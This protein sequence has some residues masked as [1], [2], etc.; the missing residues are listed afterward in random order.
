LAY[1]I[2]ARALLFYEVPPCKLFRTGEGMR[3]LGFAQQR[4]S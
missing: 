3:K 4:Q 1:A 2:W